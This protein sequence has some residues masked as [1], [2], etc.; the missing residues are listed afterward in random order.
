MAD[1]KK[2]VEIEYS[3]TPVLTGQSKVL[4]DAEK[5]NKDLTQVLKVPV[6]LPQNSPSSIGGASNAARASLAAAKSMLEIQGATEARAAYAKGLAALEKKNLKAAQ[7]ARTSLQKGTINDFVDE[8]SE[9]RKGLTEAFKKT[10]DGERQNLNAIQAARASLENAKAASAIKAAQAARASLLEAQNKVEKEKLDQLKKL[11]KGASFAS[12]SLN[13]AKSALVDGELAAQASLLKAKNAQEEK[14]SKASL[15]A[16]AA[17]VSAQQA[18]KNTTEKAEI[19][20]RKSLEKAKKVVNSKNAEELNAV[21]EARLSLARAKTAQDNKFLKASEAAQE[22]LLKAQENLRK[23]TEKAEQAARLSLFSA[24]NKI[25]PKKKIPEDPIEALL[26]DITGADIPKLVRDTESF[27]KSHNAHLKKINDAAAIQ[28]KAAEVAGSAAQEDA[29]D[30]LRRNKKHLNAGLPSDKAAT[31]AARAA[32]DEAKLNKGFVAARA[33]RLVSEE[34]RASEEDKNN[35]AAKAARVSLQR[36]QIKLVQAKEKEARDAIKAGEKLEISILKTEQKAAQ[37]KII[38]AEKQLLSNQQE[39]INEVRKAIELQRIQNKFLEK[40]G[41]TANPVVQQQNVSTTSGL[42]DGIK[43][44]TES[45]VNIGKNLVHGGL[46]AAL[47]VKNITAAALEQKRLKEI[48]ADQNAKS[49]RAQAT[50]PLVNKILTETINELTIQKQT[51]ARTTS[52]FAAANKESNRNKDVIRAINNELANAAVVAAG[53][54]KKLK[55]KFGVDSLEQAGDLADFHFNTPVFRDISKL[56]TQ[57]RLNQDKFNG[58]VEQKNNLEKRNLEISKTATKNIQEQVTAIGRVKELEAKKVRL[59]QEGE[60]ILSKLNSIQNSRIRTLSQLAA[61]E[62]RGLVNRAVNFVSGRGGSGSG[63]NGGQPPAPPGGNN[64]GGGGRGDDS[65]K[66]GA[67]GLNVFNTGMARSLTLLEK[68]RLNL[69]EADK[70]ALEFGQSARNATGR[71][72]A[73]AAPSALIYKT[74][75]A[76]RTAAQELINLDTQA[77]RLVFFEEAGRSGGLGKF[78][79]DINDSAKRSL[80]LGNAFK[81]IADEANRTGLAMEAVTE[82]AQTVSRIGEISFL[83][84]GASSD[85]LKATLGLTQIEAGALN[86]ER[87][88]E[89]LKATMAQFGLEADQI[90]GVAAKFATVANETSVNVEQ[91]ATL[92]TRFGSAAIN[93]QNLNFDQTLALASISAK[94]LG[95]NTFRTATALRQLTTK[96]VD[97]IDKVKELSGVDVTV[98]ESGQLRGIESLLEVLEKINQLG[99]TATG[100]ELAKLIGDRENLSDIFA[101]A[102]V[103]PELRGSIQKLANTQTI[104]AQSSQQIAAFLSVVGLQSDSVESSI[105]RLNTAFKSFLNSAG[106]TS[107]IDG[108]V[109]GLTSIV[110]LGTTVTESIGGI[111]GAIAALGPIA[112][113]IFGDIA[114]KGIL[115][116][117]GFIN[118]P[119]SKAQ[120]K[121]S[122][123][124]LLNT[125]VKRTETIELLSKQGLLDVQVGN[126]FLQVQNNLE[127][128][129]L[130]IEKQIQSIKVL[131]N[132][133]EKKTIQDAEKILN[134]ERARLGLERQLEGSI[135][136][137]QA[138][139]KDLLNENLTGFALLKKNFRENAGGAIASGLATAGTIFSQIIPS[140]ISSPESAQ[141]VES[142]VIK[143]FSSASIGAQVGSIFGPKGAIGGAILGGLVAT[144]QQASDKIADA[145]AKRFSFRGGPEENQEELDAEARQQKRAFT[146]I[147]ANIALREEAAK[148]SAQEVAFIEAQIRGE[149]RLNQLRNI[150]VDIALIEKQIAFNRSKGLSVE[151]LHLRLQ[152]KSAERRTLEL[153]TSKDVTNEEQRRLQILEKIASLELQQET[154]STINDIQKQTAQQLNKLNRGGSLQELR[155]GIEFDRR[156]IQERINSLVKQRNIRVDALATLTPDKKDDRDRIQKELLDIEKK[157]VTERIQANKAIREEQFAL[158]EKQEESANEIVDKYKEA[159]ASIIDAQEQIFSRNKS[160][161]SLLNDQRNLTDRRTENRNARIRNPNATND[162]TNAIQSLRNRENAVTPELQANRQATV[163]LQEDFKKAGLRLKELQAISQL[164]KEKLTAEIS[165]RQALLEAEQSNFEQRIGFERDN[166]DSLKNVAEQLVTKQ[167]ELISAEIKMIEVIKDRAKREAEFGRNLLESPEEAFQNLKNLDLAQQFLNIDKELNSR[168]TRQRFDSD[169]SGQLSQQ[170]REVAR[171][172]IISERLEKLLGKNGGRG[173]AQQILEGLQFGGGLPTD[174]FRSSSFGGAAQAEELLARLIGGGSVARKPGETNQEDRQQAT[175]DSRRKELDDTFKAM[176]DIVNQQIALER[177]VREVETERLSL[178]QK[179]VIQLKEIDLNNALNGAA[180]AAIRF[181]ETVDGSKPAFDKL[182]EIA[183]RSVTNENVERLLKDLSAASENLNRIASDNGL[184]GEQIASSLGETF[185]ESIANLSETLNNIRVEVLAEVAPINLQLEGKIKQTL[186]GEQLAAVLGRELIGTGLEDRVSEIQ[187]IITRLVEISKAQGNKFP[188][189]PPR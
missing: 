52:D 110:K 134:L 22:S 46:D 93:V 155:I 184:Q 34:A 185:N 3:V 64:R 120:L 6:S 29:N 112:S 141:K 31:D 15:A 119:E 53:I 40:Q 14:F 189:A 36:A 25:G 38:D 57:A 98:G 58:L 113:V 138:A 165:A 62:A 72:M 159:A 13:K 175:I 97:N 12:D 1:S 9:L 74:V 56:I 47:F 51:V 48:L 123:E 163:G 86:A 118:G 111:G 95:T 181:K 94:T 147:R 103:V 26:Q 122:F 76:I 73:F 153:Q 68:I 44:A 33:A 61:A 5:L 170:E 149:E 164:S 173:I 171:N 178:I 83:P 180:A 7:A 50:I 104:A 114:K 150:N 43:K 126:K 166:L 49:A 132:N 135:K 131:I 127:R 54:D 79:K 174:P 87:A 8:T 140:F 177:Q 109:K 88:A 99:Q 179:Q 23:T 66:K 115:S 107:I 130:A 169:K 24:K 124:T 80:L 162:I 16:Q 101:L 55:D 128:N 65:F 45:A 71:L 70:A 28:Q 187:G 129:K 35:K 142:S 137:Q 156:Q 2:L 19:A 81:N 186:D 148:K 176:N 77:R 78:N 21:D 90:T 27:L 183:T 96:L 59:E 75:A 67:A 84:G 125:P 121:K 92:V 39:R 11:D 144:L 188:P 17:L 105:N 116:L 91:L 18:L 69:N 30:I 139:T 146:V 145:L 157:I 182:N 133:E 143:I 89:I 160:I 168:G 60:G 102:K 41:R 136:R 172:S 117:I 32:L 108:V 37:K 158:L 161:I 106:T 4:K 154:R 82:A 151:E 152:A 10:L 42:S 167:Q 100:V 85:F 20:A 63:G